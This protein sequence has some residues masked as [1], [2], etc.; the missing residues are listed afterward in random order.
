M[1]FWEMASGQGFVN[2]PLLDAHC[3]DV[4]HQVGETQIAH[5]LPKEQRHA[6]HNHQREGLEILENQFHSDFFI[7]SPFTGP[8]PGRQTPH[9]RL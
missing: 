4:A 5:G 3:D 1:P 7:L 2:A 6:E 9:F 8:P